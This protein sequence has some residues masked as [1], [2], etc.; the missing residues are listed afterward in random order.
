VPNK[1]EHGKDSRQSEIQRRLDELEEAVSQQ[2]LNGVN[3]LAENIYV[4]YYTYFTQCG[5]T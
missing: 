1:D 5:L 2:Y 4:T 3:L